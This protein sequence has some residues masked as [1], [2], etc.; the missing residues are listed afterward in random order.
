MKGND[1]GVGSSARTE[2]QKT[3]HFV[4]IIAFGVRSVICLQYEGVSVLF[5]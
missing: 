4:V 3:A 2:I 5:G 1:A